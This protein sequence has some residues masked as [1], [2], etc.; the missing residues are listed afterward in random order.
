ML[1]PEPDGGSGNSFADISVA[2]GG[3]V[4]ASNAGFGISENGGQPLLDAIHDLQVQVADALR[5]SANLEQEPPLGSTPNAKIYKP[6]IATVASD[7][8]QGAVTVLK[9]LHDDLDDA[10]AAIQKSIS[11]YERAD[12]GSATNFGST[13]I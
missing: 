11:N 9:R 7:P 3:L 8:T 12:E 10:Y 6:F 13:A 1:T 4:E 5:D 2:V